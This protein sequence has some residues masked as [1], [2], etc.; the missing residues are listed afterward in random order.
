[1]IDRK[2]PSLLCYGMVN[3]LS[4]LEQINFD[5]AVIPDSGA[6]HKPEQKVIASDWRQI[7]GATPA[8]VNSQFHIDSE[9]AFLLSLKWAPSVFREL[10]S[11][12]R[13]AGVGLIQTAI[14]AGVL[15]ALVLNQLLAVR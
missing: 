8:K 10:E 1:M 15:K 14:A 3:T 11:E 13:N 9:R 6:D 2:S 4:F 7:T 12:A 5:H